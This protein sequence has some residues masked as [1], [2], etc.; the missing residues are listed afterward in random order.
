[1]SFWINIVPLWVKITNT[2]NNMK[3][4]L[5][6]AALFTITVIGANAQ[7][8]PIFGQFALGMDEETFN[9]RLDTM[10]AHNMVKKEEYGLT[11]TDYEFK[12]GGWTFSIYSFTLNDMNSF[13]YGQIK[14]EN[15]NPI[16]Y[17]NVN[18][19]IDNKLTN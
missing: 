18:F 6:L 16:E 2:H 3:K 8:Y 13:W 17:S 19:T 4:I 1:M 12:L 5:L 15:F 11:T 10:K 14:E 7:T 9:E